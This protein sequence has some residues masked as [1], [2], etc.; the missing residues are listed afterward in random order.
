[1][2]VDELHGIFTTYEM[3]MGHNEPS[4]KE[5]ALKS[6]SKNQLENLDKEEVI[7]ISKLDRG[8]QKYKG[9]LPLKCF[10]VEELDIFPISVLTQNKRRVI[11]KNLVVISV[12]TWIRRSLRKIRKTSIPKNIVTMKVKMH[13]SYSW[14]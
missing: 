4:R 10:N 8:T 12:R 13:K 6:L 2:T 11:V 1:M 3:R 9:K 7:F 5:A 14:E